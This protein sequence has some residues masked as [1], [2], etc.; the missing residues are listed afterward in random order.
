MQYYWYW[1]FMRFSPDISYPKS[2]SIFVG[3]FSACPSHYFAMSQRAAETARQN[4]EC[5]GHVVA[6]SFFLMENGI[7]PILDHSDI[8]WGYH[9]LIFSNRFPYLS[10]AVAWENLW[11]NFRKWTSWNSPAI[12][13]SSLDQNGK[14]LGSLFLN[15]GI[16]SKHLLAI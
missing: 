8:N 6:S 15:G 14:H 1:R 3:P 4:A 10:M 2:V 12:L 5:S 16:S 9:C 7:L 11:Q 13:R